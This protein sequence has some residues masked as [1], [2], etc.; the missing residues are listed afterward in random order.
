MAGAGLRS[1]RQ[2]GQEAHMDEANE[3]RF[4]VLVLS[5][6][7]VVLALICSCTC[8]SVALIGSLGSL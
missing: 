7:A 8:I 3:S 6:L 4:M 1:G 5:I 2:D